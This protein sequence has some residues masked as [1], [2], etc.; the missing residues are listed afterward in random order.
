M[1]TLSYWESEWTRPWMPFMGC[2]QPA[3]SSSATEAEA[4]FYRC[5]TGASKQL[6]LYNIWLVGGFGM[7]LDYDFFHSVGNGMSIIPT[8]ELPSF[9]QRGRYTTNQ[10]S[11]FSFGVFQH[12]HFSKMS[13]FLIIIVG[14][15]SASRH[16]FRYRVAINASRWCLRLFP[17]GVAVASQGALLESHLFGA[18]GDMGRTKNIQWWSNSS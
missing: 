14:L 11:L 17:C 3:R 6:K 8:D 1:D 4:S 16:L 9:F 5:P 18:L 13:P 15:F 2:Q 7:W 12:C 10:I